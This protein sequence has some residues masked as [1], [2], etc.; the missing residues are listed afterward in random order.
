MARGLRNSGEALFTAPGV[1]VLSGAAVILAIPGVWWLARSADASHYRSLVIALVVIVVLVTVTQGKPY[2]AGP[3]TPVLFAAGA[4]A[5]VTTSTGWVTAMVAWGVLSI[6]LATPFL[7]VSTADGVLIAG[8]IAD[9]VKPPIEI[10]IH[11]E[12]E[13]FDG[14]LKRP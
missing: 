3:F 8:E 2:Y 12:R 4:V 5:G 10:T 9:G 6:P 7:P 14:R 13:C 11:H 1:I